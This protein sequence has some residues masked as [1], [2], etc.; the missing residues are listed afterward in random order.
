MK[1]KN[2][3]SSAERLDGILHLI[4]N[5][6]RVNVETICKEFKVSPATARRDLKYLH[7]QGSIMRVHGGATS[8]RKSPPEN[9][10]FQRMNNN[11]D[12]KKNIG[13]A[14]A[15]LINNGDTI[16][17]GSGTTA[18]EVS[19]N[20]KSFEDLTVITNSV[21]V[22]N[23]LISCKNIMLVALGGIVRKSEFSMIGNLTEAAL[24]GL[25]ADKVIIGIHGVDLQQGLTNHYL[26]E[27]MTDRKI[28]QM[29]RKI[30]IVADHTKCGVISTSQVAPISI[31]HTFITDKDAPPDFIQSLIDLGINVVQA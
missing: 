30:F 19:R 12:Y 8:L 6:K 10:V 28:L 14:T 31:V 20:I 13:I 1:L 15:A 16:F 4:E 11:P 7:N 24:S 17:I 27:T 2:S 22:I 9:P 23:E 29:G 25:Y 3:L 18:Y 26:P 21:L 5:N